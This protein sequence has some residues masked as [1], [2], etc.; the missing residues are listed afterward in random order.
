MDV[1]KTLRR[2]RFINYGKRYHW[3]ESKLYH[4]IHHKKTWGR[5]SKK[6]KVRSRRRGKEEVGITLTNRREKEKGRRRKERRE[7]SRTREEESYS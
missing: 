6:D 5:C 4:K 7:T 2:I 1:I 3:P